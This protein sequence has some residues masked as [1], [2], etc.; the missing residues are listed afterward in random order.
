M[1]TVAAESLDFVNREPGLAMDE[2]IAGDAKALS[3]QLQAL[4]AKLFPPQARKQL[5]RFSSGEAARLIGVTDS[6]L[7]HLALGGEGPEPEK[8]AAGRRAY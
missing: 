7:R 2:V 3:M 1:P 4:R 6:Y 8:N 5:R